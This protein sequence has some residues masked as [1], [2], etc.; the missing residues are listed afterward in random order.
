MPKTDFHI[1]PYTSRY[2]VSLKKL[3]N[4]L[5]QWFEPEAADDVL[6]MINADTGLI[7]LD[8]D[9]RVIGFMVVCFDD[10][11][12]DGA[13][14]QWAGV[15][16]AWHRRGVGR[17]MFNWMLNEAT[18]AGLER[19]YVETMSDEVDYPPF[20]QTR[21]FYAKLGF[22]TYRDLGDTAHNGLLTTDWVFHI[23]QSNFN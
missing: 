7:A 14:I 20:E 9:D 3:V 2:A 18:D 8:E 12:F 10:E 5:E 13:R 15:H 4:R 16:P 6:E 17:A 21:Q 19:I 23:T 11:D 1:I 22:E